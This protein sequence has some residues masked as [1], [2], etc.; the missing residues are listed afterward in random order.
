M[1]YFAKRLVL[2]KCLNTSIPID[3]LFDL[4]SLDSFTRD[5]VRKMLSYV[6]VEPEID[7]EDRGHKIPFFSDMLFS[8]NKRSIN[9]LFFR[10]QAEDMGNPD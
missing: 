9:D 5:K 2:I 3:H 1:D 4:D 6:T 7:T 10:S 8:Y